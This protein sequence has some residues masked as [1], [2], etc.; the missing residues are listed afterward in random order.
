VPI[1]LSS[2]ADELAL[3]EQVRAWLQAEVPAHPLPS[4]DTAAGFE[5]HRAWEKK[6][7]EG[8]WSAVTWPAEYG[9]RGL[10]HALHLIVEEEYWAAGAPLR[11]NQNGIQLLGPTLLA[12]GSDEQKA[13][14]LPR[15][16]AGLDIWCQGWSEP[17]AGSDLAAIRARA[18]LSDDGTH[19]SVTGQKTWCSR[20]AYADWL[21]GLFRSDPSAERHRGLTYL[22]IPMTADGITVRPIPQLDGEAGFAEVFFDD[23]R[24]EMANTLGTP[25]QGWRIAMA[26]AGFE[27]G[28]SLRSPGRFTARVRRLAELLASQGDADAAARD[29]VTSVWIDAEAYRLHTLM[30]VSRLLEGDQIGAETSMNKVFWSEMDLRIHEVALDILGPEAELLARDPVAGQRDDAW[31][32]G[33]MAALGAPIFAGTNEIQRTI[34]A[35]RVLGLPRE[36]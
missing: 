5:A 12:A 18:T 16:A 3:R 23:V 11:V 36:S 33:W 19:W 27:R 15:M 17:N 8:R 26:T 6:L 7:F 22:L 4:L 13:R 34:I 1:D 21:F 24:V 14:F 30:T 9:G 32:D 2:T 10:D 29:A 20:G 35:D 28:V 25:G 31:L